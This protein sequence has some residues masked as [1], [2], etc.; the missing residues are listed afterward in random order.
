[1]KI[2]R[3]VRLLTK[4]SHGN[5]CMSHE[6]MVKNLRRRYNAIINHTEVKDYDDT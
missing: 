5:A 4:M 6:S 2:A 3:V 1:M